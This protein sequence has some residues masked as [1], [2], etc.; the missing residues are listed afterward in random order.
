MHGLGITFRGSR[1]PDLMRDARKVYGI[2]DPPLSAKSKN[3]LNDLLKEGT[4]TYATVF[5]H[6]D[7]SVLRLSDNPQVSLSSYLRK[8]LIFH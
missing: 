2:E 7:G 8:L 6:Q 5:F 3:T 4:F 1:V